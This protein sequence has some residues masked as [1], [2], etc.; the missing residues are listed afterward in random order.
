[1]RRLRGVLQ[2][3]IAVTSLLFVLPLIALPQ[4]VFVSLGLPVGEFALFPRLLGIAYAALLV[5]YAFGLRDLAKGR[6]PIVAVCTGIVSNGGATAAFVTF[7]LMGAYTALP[8]WLQWYF[9]ISAAGAAQVT[10]ELASSLRHRQTF[11]VT[12]NT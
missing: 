4:S 8:T 10:L 7:G 5:S 6:Y 11:A 12:S 1:M 2:R 9:W 3:K